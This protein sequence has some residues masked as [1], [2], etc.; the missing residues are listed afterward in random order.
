M[1]LLNLYQ[2]CGVRG[3]EVE[4]ALSTRDTTRGCVFLKTIAAKCESWLAD[5]ASH[6]SINDDGGFVYL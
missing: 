3:S 4:V 5:V 6:P 2:L 1:S